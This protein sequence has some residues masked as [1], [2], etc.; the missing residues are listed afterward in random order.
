MATTCY[1]EEIITDQNGD[2]TMEVEFGRSSFYSGAKLLNGKAGTDSIYLTVNGES[3]IMD[4]ETAKKFVEAAVS[5]GHYH[6]LID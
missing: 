5:V 4:R 2:R 1:F 6:G 3:V